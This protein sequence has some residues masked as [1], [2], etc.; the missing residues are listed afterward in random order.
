MTAEI[1]A[2][3][4]PA[5]VPDKS[6]AVLPFVDMSENHDQEYF[7]DGMVEEII[8]RLSK[9]PALHVPA[10][11]SSFY[12]KGKSTRLADIARELRV[13]N[14]MEGSVRKSG[15]HLRIGAQ[16]V[17]IK[18]GYTVWSQSFDRRLKDVFKI[19]DEIATAVAAALQITLSGGPLTREQGGTQNLEAYQLCLRAVSNLR[20]NTRETIKNARSQLEQALKL[21][22]TFGLAWYWLSE[23]W[24]IKT[25]IGDVTP[26][27]GFE[28]AR[29]FATRAIA[30]SPGIAEPHKALAYVYRSYDWNWT[31]ANAELQRALALN[32]GNP[33][34]VMLAGQ[35]AQ[36]LG[37]R[38]EAERLLRAALVRDPL[39]SW[40]LFNLGNAQYVAGRY[41]GAEA[42]FRRVLAVAPNFAW[43]R[44][45]LAKTLLAESKPREALDVLKPTINDDFALLYS[46]VILLANARQAEAEAAVQRLVSQ[47]GAVS[48]FY[49][50]Q[51]YAYANDKER[52][53]YWLERAYNQKDVGLVDIV[54]EPLFKNLTNDPR[55]KAF[56][57]KMNLPE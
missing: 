49:V 56:L 44:A 27:D 37:R 29:H 19:Q 15:D 55:Y 8:E 12:F 31:A 14:I 53:M 9:V 36:T 17:R 46:P 38:D 33:E 40:G 21:D 52:A 51:Y 20:E 42:T 6:I 57:R 1:K 30:V 43:T 39:F 2:V 34:A 5:A 28:R 23:T 16:M 11:A 22:P 7:G 3:Y 24:V 47:Q 45:W 18:D 32:S 10:R 13:A 54:G 48:A 50:A 35:L 26:S 25:E 4:T 41:T